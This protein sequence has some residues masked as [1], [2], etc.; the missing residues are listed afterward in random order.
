M[1]KNSYYE[2]SDIF[3]YTRD[4]YIWMFY[5]YDIFQKYTCAHELMVLVVAAQ[6]LLIFNLIFCMKLFIETVK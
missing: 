5:K 6:N 1:L 2:F 3:F 4:L